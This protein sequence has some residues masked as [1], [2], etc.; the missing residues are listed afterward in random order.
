MTS[1]PRNLYRAAAVRALEDSA[2]DRSGLTGLALM[3]R[4]GQAAFAVQQQYWPSARRM[5]VVCGPGNNGGDGFVVARLAAAAGMA[6]EVVLLADSERLSGAAAQAYADMLAAGVTG[7]AF[8]AIDL[9]TADILVDALFGTGL[10]RD[11]GGDLAVVI[12]ALNACRAPVLAV[13]IPSGLHADSGRVQGH[14]VLAAVTVSFVALKLGLLTGQGPA[15]CGDLV[16]DDLQLSSDVGD[17]VPVAARRIDYA[18]VIATEDHP[19]VLRS[20]CAHKGNFGHV[21]VVGGDQAMAGAVRMA[22]EAAARVGAGLVSVAT[23]AE[24]A[25][26]IC[27][28]RPELMVHGVVSTGVLSPLLAQATVVALG[29]GLGQQG[30]GQECFSRVLEVAMAA[31][32]PLVID[33]DGLNLLA[34]DPC[35]YDHWLLTPHPGEAARL[36]GVTTAEI[37]ND[38]L[39]A[40]QAIQQRYGGVCILKGAGTLIQGG[41]LCWLCSDGNPG[42]A[43][44]GMGDVLSGVIAGLLAQGLALT[45]AAMVAVCLHAHAADE[46]AREGERGMLAMDLMPM[47]RRLVNPVSAVLKS[48]EKALVC[49]S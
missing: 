15:C 32:I 23:R 29:P 48:A 13:D 14:V 5:I 9:N 27:A 25:H 43:S 31:A 26:Q 34:S 41:D 20:R 45:D 37:Q 6:V 49:D 12:D 11:I 21:L 1:L 39:A 17:G 30:W 24:H 4:A 3:E 33:A 46:V 36:L 42:M 38:R 10:D 19:L 18:G 8:A 47:L 22:A 40:A 44:G 2:I 16:F 28:A 7:Q 35:R